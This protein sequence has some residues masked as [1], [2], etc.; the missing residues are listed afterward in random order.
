MERP[1]LNEYSPFYQKYIDK[2]PEGDI[3][4]ILEHSKQQLLTLLENTPTDKYAYR[5]AEGKWSMKETLLHMIDAERIFSYRA[6]RIAR[7]DQTPLS[8]FD[9]DVYVPESEATQ[10]TWQ[11]I[12]D[13]YKAV[14]DASIHLFKNISKE[15]SLRR[16][17]VSS[18]VISVRALAYITAGHELHHLQLFIEK[19]LNDN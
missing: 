8:G 6:L 12:V 14:R 5:Y 13:E 17:V 18:A 1:A 3:I 4:F 11:S 16:G 10:R 19:Y 15:A 2:V 9:Q 7:N